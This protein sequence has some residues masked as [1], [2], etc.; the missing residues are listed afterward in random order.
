MRFIV[1]AVFG[2]MVIMA[3]ARP[4]PSAL[5]SEELWERD[6]STCDGAAMKSMS[7]FHLW[8]CTSGGLRV[9]CIQLVPLI[10]FPLW[11]LVL[12]LQ[13]R[14]NSVSRAMKFSDNTAPKLILLKDVINDAAC[15]G[16]AI[17]LGADFVSTVSSI[18]SS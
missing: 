14:E 7:V 13:L 15:I 11:R 1:A 2:Y 6:S 18:R 4:L 17:Q 3:S 16:A 10:W 8:Q 5:N 9:G 12:L